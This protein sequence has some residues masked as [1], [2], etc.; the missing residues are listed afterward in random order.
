MNTLLGLWI[1]RVTHSNEGLLREAYAAFARG[2]LDGF[3]KLCVPDV[4]FT[5]PGRNSLSGR[6]ASWKAF[7]EALGPLIQ[8]TQ[9]TYREDVTRVIATD[10]DGCVEVAAHVQRDGKLLKWNG[11][12][13]Y[14]IRNGKLADF[15]EFIDNQSAFD[16]AWK[17]L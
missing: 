12:H 2:D 8:A 9:G 5:V 3:Y 7:L 13:L 4:T 17:K 1:A 15:R 11:I 14:Q 6:Q 10:T 16:E